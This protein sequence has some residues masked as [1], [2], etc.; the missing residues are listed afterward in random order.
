[1]Q[2]GFALLVSC[3]G[4]RLLMGQ[5]AIDEV[6]AAAEEIARRHALVGFYSYGEISPHSASRT[7]QLHN[8]TMTVFSV[9]ERQPTG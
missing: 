1:S 6:T 4:R 7:L 5:R 8:Q 3:I 2:E 9:R